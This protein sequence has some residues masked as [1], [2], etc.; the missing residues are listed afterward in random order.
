VVDVQPCCAQCAAWLQALQALLLP[1]LHLCCTSG[2]T[3]IAEAYVTPEAAVLTQLYT[4]L[5]NDYL[6]EVRHC[7]GRLLV[8]NT[9]VPGHSGCLLAVWRAAARFDPAPHGAGWQSSYLPLHPSLHPVLV[10]QRLTCCMCW[11]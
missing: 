3:V 7:R 11:R 6:S 1:L 8:C 2:C 10:L 5:L 9:A 4:K